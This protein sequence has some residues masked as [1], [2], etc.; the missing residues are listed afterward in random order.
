MPPSR[1]AAAGGMCLGPAD[2]KHA[3][4]VGG[5]K[6]GPTPQWRVSIRP[7]A[8]AALAAYERRAMSTAALIRVVL[9]VSLAVFA[10]DQISKWYVL[11]A[12]G[13][14][15]R[16]AIP[17]LPPFLNFRMAWNTGINFGLFG[18]GP[19]A[20]RWFLIALS[21]IVSAVLVWWVLRRRQG[22]L[23]V[24]AG[25]VLGGA[26]GNA[27]DRLR[28]GAVADFLNTSCCG[29]NNPFSFNIADVAIFAGAVWLAIKA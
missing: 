11:E 17:V 25:L 15:E 7:L 23:A 9:L 26:L 5:S 22:A 12:L 27:V 19:G 29:I 24:G 4:T 10:A 14:R 1:A 21:I 3:A 20:A 13:L 18:G 28:H 2:E 16:L 8:G 6:T